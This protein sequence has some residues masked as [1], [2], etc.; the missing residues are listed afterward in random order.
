MSDPRSLSLFDEVPAIEARPPKYWIA[1]AS[2][3]H[4]SRGR[5]DGFMQVCH[6][7]VAPLKR[8]HAGDVV[9]YYSP[10]EKFGG[11]QALQAF[12]ALGV[13]KAGNPYQVQM[14]PDFCPYR[15]DVAWLP[16]RQ[17]AIRPLLPLLDFSAGK[18]NWGYQLRFGLFEISA[19]DM[20][21]IASAMDVALP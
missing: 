7:K 20:S 1:V 14:A 3:E 9:A 13:V 19:S 11:T 5:A 21:Q 15:R 16:A 8:I 2:G 6:G 4:V 17:A 12:T 10:T 18:S